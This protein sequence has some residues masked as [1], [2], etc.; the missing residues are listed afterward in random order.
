VDRHSLDYVSLLFGVAFTA[1]GISIAGGVLRLQESGIDSAI[2]L[3]IGFVGLVLAA[4]TL[5]RYS[6]AHDET[7]KA[8]AVP[9][10]RPDEASDETKGAPDRT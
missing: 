9:H 10:S 5:N 4:V 1:L 2:P 8:D 7:A 3:G 6:R